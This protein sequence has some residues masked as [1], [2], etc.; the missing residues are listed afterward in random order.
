MDSSTKLYIPQEV[1]DKVLFWV[2]HKDMEVSGFGKIKYVP[3]AQRFEVVDAYL[4]DQVGGSAHTDIDDASLSRLMYEARTVEGELSWWWHS[5]V[6]MPV[7]WSGTDT[8]TI[9]DL[10]KNGWIVASVFNQREEVRSALCYAVDVSYTSDFGVHTG[11][12][13]RLID[14][15]STFIANPRPE[16]ARYAGWIEQYTKHVKEE[17]RYTPPYGSLWSE[18]AATKKETKKEKTFHHGP[19][20]YVGDH[21]LTEAEWDAYTQSPHGTI[22]QWKEAKAKP[23]IIDTNLCHTCGEPWRYCLCYAGAVEG[24]VGC[25]PKDEAEY[26]GVDLEYYLDV[27]SKSNLTQAETDAMYSWFEDLKIGIERGELKCTPN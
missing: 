10:G 23:S 22:D 18:Q 8:S 1:W 2:R 11:K 20:V 6:K 14:N 12:D 4:L 16:D 25:T 7:F 5:H 15:I 17:P 27:I 13:V 3:E 26:L 9:K 21:V 19:N 24:L